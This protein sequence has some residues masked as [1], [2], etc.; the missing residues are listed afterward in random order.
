MSDVPEPWG[1]EEKRER[2][3]N[4]KW[5]RQEMSHEPRMRMP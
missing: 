2:W 3:T 5:R 4:W 1:L